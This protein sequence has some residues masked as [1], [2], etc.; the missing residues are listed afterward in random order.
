MTSELSWVRIIVEGHCIWWDMIARWYLVGLIGF[1]QTLTCFLLG[2]DQDTHSHYYFCYRTKQKN[3]SRR[4]RTAAL[5]VRP[6]IVLLTEAAVNT[7][8]L[9]APLIL[10]AVQ[11]FAG[12]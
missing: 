6:R 8:F 7:V 12:V 11:L 5:V 4:A 3:I 2:L 1:N 9:T 10:C